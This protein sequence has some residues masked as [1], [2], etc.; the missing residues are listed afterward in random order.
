MKKLIT[1]LISMLLLST[2]IN[3][4]NIETV[5]YSLIERI[6]DKNAH[7]H[8]GDVYPSDPIPYYGL[9]DEI[10]AWRFNYSIGEPFPTEEQLLNERK[11]YESAGDKR[12][13]WGGGKFGRFLISARPNLPVMIES[14]GCLSPEYAEAAKLERMLTEAFNG[15]TAEFVKAYYFNHFN[16]WYKYRSG[17]T[18]KYINLSPTGGIIDHDEFE[19]RRKE[20]AYFIQP[21]DFSEDW[22]KYLDGFTDETDAAKYIPYYQAMPYYDWSYG[23]SPTAGAMLLAYW[24]VTSLFETWKYGGFVQYHYQRADNVAGG[25][26]YNVPNVQYLLALAM[27]TDTMS[28]STMPHA[29]DNGYEHVC[30]SVMPY[31]F[32]VGTHYSLH[33]TRTKEE[34]DAGRPLHIDISGHSVCAI[35]YNESNNKVYTHYTWDPEI[36]SISRWSMLHLVTVHP[37]GSTGDAVYLRRPFGDPRYNGDGQGEDLYEGDFY[38]IL[39][40]ADKYYGNTSVDL[41]YSIDGGYDFNL[42]ELGA[43]NCGYYNWQVPTGIASNDCR[44]MVYLQDSEFAPYIAAADGS[45]GNFQIHSGGSVPELVHAVARSTD[46][47][48][49]YYRFEHPH[50]SWAIVGAFPE[51]SDSRWSSEL[52]DENFE[53]MTMES[54]HLVRHNFVVLDG[55]HLPTETYGIKVRPHD[56]DTTVYVQYEGDNDNLSLTPGASYQ[57]NWQADKYVEMQDIH[58][59]PGHYYFEM[60]H[61][62]GN[63][64]VD[65]AFF[66]STDGSYFSRIWDA[67]YISENYGS[68]KESFVVEITEE[69]DYG[70]CFFLKERGSGMGSIS[71]KIDEAFIWTGAESSNWHDPDN[72][73]GHM[74]PNSLSKVV[75]GNVATDPHITDGNANCAS[76]NIQRDGKLY[77][78]DFNLMIGNNLNLYGSLYIFDP[79]SRIS[80]YGDVLAVKH[81]YLEMTEGS[82]MY[83][84]GDWTFDTD[85]YLQL[86]HGFVNFTGDEM[87][88]IYVKSDNCGFYDLIVTKTDDAFA[89]FDM[90]PGG[91]Y[92]LRIK[93]K[94]QIEPDAKYV[95]FSMNPTILDGPYLAYIDSEVVFPSGKFVFNHPGPGGP[96]VY[97]SPGSYFN[98]V[99]INVE[100]W[101]V[102]S[103]DIEIRGS[104]AITDGILKANGYDIYIKGNWTNYSGF[105]HGDAR[106]IFNGGGIQEVDGENF[107]ELE[108]DKLGGELRFHEYYTSAEYFDWTQGTI[109][110]NGGEFEAFDLLDNGIYGNYILTDGQIDLHQGTGS[111]QFID[112]N[113]NLEITGGTMNVHGGST[114]SY[115]AYNGNASIIMEDGVLD[116]KDNSARVYGYSEYTFTEDITGGTIRISQSFMVDNDEFT[117]NGGTLHFYNYDDDAI[118]DVDEES[119]VF[120]LTIDKSSKSKAIASTLTAEGILNING[121]FNLDG[122]VFEAPTDMYLAGHFNNNLT[123]SHFDELMGEV[124]LD[125]DIDITYPEGEEFYNLTINKDDAAVY[126][127]EGQTLTAQK[128]FH[129]D[130]GQFFCSP[131]TSLLIDGGLNVDHGGELYLLGGGGE[132]ISVTS[133]SK[134]DYAFDINAG[135]DIAAENV[136]FSNMDTDGVN[137]HSGA[138]LPGDM[139]FKNCTFKD[140]AAGGTLITWD[141]GANLVIFNAVFPTNTTG[142]TYNVTKN[143][144][145]GYLNF[146]NATGDFAGEAY[147]NDLYDRVNWEYVPPFDLPFIEDWAS[148]DFETNNW[149]ATGAN[150]LVVPEVGNPE[151]SAK[152]YYLPRIYD[153]N[154]DLRTHFLDATEYETVFL[155]YDIMFDEFQSQTIEELFVRVVFENGDFYT[156][157]TYNNQG[158]S[159]EW[160]TESFDISSYIA[161]E[162][163]KVYFRAHGQDSYYLDGWF[164]DNISVSGEMPEPGNLG[165]KVYDDNTGEILV[166]A[167]VHIEGTAL[168]DIT[169]EF[170]KYL[171]ENLAPGNYDVTASMDGYEP[172]TNFNVLVPSGLTGQSMFYLLPLPPSYCT[173]GLYTTGCDLGDG[174]ED[175]SLADIKNIGSGCSPNAYGDFTYLSTDLVRGYM[176]PVEMASGFGY[177]NVSVWIDFNDD[178]EF[179]ESE[180][181]LT[182]FYIQNAGLTYQAAIMVPA[183]APEGLHRLRARANWDEPC[184]DPCITYE[185]G[186]VED[187]SVNIVSGTLLANLWATITDQSSGD[188]VAEAEIQLLDTEYIGFSEEEGV[189]FL[190]DMMPGIYDV[191]VSKFG[192]ETQ[193]IEGVY[194]Y[195]VGL[196]SLDIALVPLPILTQNIT[197]PQGWSGLSTY[198]ILQEPNMMITLFD[199]SNQLIILQ[200]NQGMFWPGQQ[201]YTLQSWERHSAYKIKVSNEA[202]L[203]LTGYLESNLTCNLNNGWNLLPVICPVNV[204]VSELF[205]AKNGG[206]VIV[207]DVAGTGVFW[208]DM[209]I[210]SL[211]I[212]ETGR[213]YHVLMNAPATVTYPESPTKAEFIPELPVSNI[214]ENWNKP[215]ETHSSHVVGFP[216][217]IWEGSSF[218]MGDVLG[219]FTQ[220]EICV[221][222]ARI[223]ENM[224]ITLFADDP[225]TGLKEGLSEGEVLEFKVFNIESNSVQPIEI[226]WD[227]SM[228]D[229]DGVFHSDGLSV[230]VSIKSGAAGLFVDQIPNIKIYPNP[231]DGKVNIH[232][233]MPDAEI[234]VYDSHGRNILNNIT[235]D[236]TIHLD[237][238]WV[239]EGIYYIRI[240][241]H[242][243]I[244]IEKIVV[245]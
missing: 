185:Y 195:G 167:L 240:T 125:G 44:V 225:L 219:A 54:Y 215:T 224:A 120:N 183:D 12:Q 17:Q 92:P 162:V 93:G 10:I 81:G 129:V 154:V 132:S 98:N 74:V 105:N 115:W 130:K 166:G 238:S 96:G 214:P 8:W 60:T 141:N 56:G 212:L 19:T 205:G 85:I 42:I 22:Q 122:G 144:D 64:D 221:G 48:A 79:D 111:G 121:D 88:L 4:Q 241:N 86:N 242:D 213:A 24:D 119:N 222:L 230:A 204:S 163:F 110:V 142:S 41:F 2:F 14:S 228:P 216:E 201:V 176:Y 210:N 90:C 172:K 3:S 103:S 106:V 46:T 139:I 181:M 66:S 152:F 58:L 175:F 78:D 138:Y 184:S 198:L 11:D 189:C 220:D 36:T 104:L 124:I 153:Y 179:E 102:L 233:L 33:W 57:L 59:T 194:I 77:V 32:N 206:L 171:F 244:R 52:W 157:A 18:I 164:I 50:P 28:G 135:G 5:Q 207:K 177:Q 95:G 27:D 150:W 180:R 133:G 169:N 209:G 114:D 239:Q 87:S 91:N 107:Y 199:V 174:F 49:E 35:G 234:V 146:E 223:H 38:E 82:G 136:V 170:G 161:G 55:N 34:I 89:A 173:E 109:R 211:G 30:N 112:L 159:F 26:D 178:F 70:I 9:D 151:P 137:I 197:I 16:T 76:L 99:E 134:G 156:V 149:T 227:V 23:C 187:Y 1:T 67:D 51:T 71:I 29:M 188:P 226:T 84:Y 231:T 63:M 73:V 83:V 127:T 202:Y 243:E 68:T 6:A 113:G 193:I 116:F 147:E 123:P 25:D 53:D 80:C 61:G 94:F 145:N 69:D 148:E 13:M 75:I 40:A 108:I 37:G 186:E 140:G 235:S 21:D 39:W 126:L 160:V 236:E 191:Q 208:P 165:G 128:I 131:G 192:Y 200:N 97:C 245:Y 229:A 7:S 65:M 155:S 190:Y 117:P 218:E 31:N 237:L 203:G 158:G 232:G 168:S 196:N 100:Y 118:I 182:D 143:V 43:E 101:V 47:E 45:Y 217:G 20:A 62:V 15:Q 72:W